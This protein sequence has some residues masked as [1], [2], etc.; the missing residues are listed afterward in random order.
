MLPA[1]RYAY[2]SDIEQHAEDQVHDGGTD[3]AAAYPDNIEQQR[4][5]TAIS[6]G[7]DDLFTKR[8]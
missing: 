1:K 8:R 7:A 2:N 5:A 6:A 4:K 3:A